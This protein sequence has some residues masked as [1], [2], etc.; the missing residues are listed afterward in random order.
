[1]TANRLT[2]FRHRWAD[3]HRDHE[4]ITGPELAIIQSRFLQAKVSVWAAANHLSISV[5]LP[6]IFPEADWT[7]FVAASIMQCLQSAAG[8]KMLKRGGNNSIFKLFVIAI[9]RVVPNKAHAV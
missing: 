3:G 1:V 8:T 4:E 5:I 6:I 7:Y 2:S 9:P